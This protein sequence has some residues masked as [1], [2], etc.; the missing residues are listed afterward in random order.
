MSLSY[1]SCRG[2]LPA[3]HHQPKFQLIQRAHL[4]KS[5]HVHLLLNRYIYLHQPNSF[6]LSQHAHISKTRLLY[7]FLTRS[8]YLYRERPSRSHTRPSSRRSSNYK[9][10][11]PNQR[12][13]NQNLK[14]NQRRSL[15]HCWATYRRTRMRLLFLIRQVKTRQFMPRLAKS[16]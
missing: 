15:C 9:L 7:L 11:P 6:Q 4:V 10:S 16:L 1:R 5:H 12:K 2:V 8:M 14:R 3:S 13:L